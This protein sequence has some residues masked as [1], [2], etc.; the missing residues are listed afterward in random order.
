M[1]IVKKVLLVLGIELVI[2]F[3]LC[4]GI[5]FIVVKP[6]QLEVPSS[7]KYKFL[8][9]L[10][11]F[12]DFLPSIFATSIAM[13]YSWGF[14]RENIS[15]KTK[16]SSEIGK[17]LTAII[18]ISFISAA[19]CFVSQE[20]LIRFTENSKTKMVINTK[21]IL[22]YLDMA[23]K[24]YEKEEYNDASFYIKSVLDLNKNHAEGNA[25]KVQI[26]NKIAESKNIISSNSL[27]ENSEKTQK[28]LAPNEDSSKIINN[29]SDKNSM[30]ATQL[31]KLAQECFQTEDFINAHY[32]ASQVVDLCSPNETNYSVAKRLATESWANLSKTKSFDDELSSEVFAKKKESYVA[33]ISGNYSKAYYNFSDLIEKYPR[34]IDIKKYFEQAK[35]KL[36]SQCFFIDETENLQN[37]EQY[38]NVYFTIPNTYG[39]K[40]IVSIAGVTSIKSR[41]SMIMYLRD[42]SIFSYDKNDGLLSKMTVPYAKL[43]PFPI[44]DIDAATR[45]IVE[46][47][48]KTEFVPYIFL[49]S[50]DRKD[51]NVFIEPKYEYFTSNRKEFSTISILPISLDQFTMLCDVSNG[52]NR[53]NIISLFAFSKDAETYGYSREILSHSLLSRILFPLI[54]FVC[55]LFCG[56]IAWDTKLTTQDSFHFSWIILFPFLTVLAYSLIKIIVYFCDLTFY[57]LFGIAGSYAILIA[58]AIFV[59]IA[60]GL[61]IKI[62][63]VK[64]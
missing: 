60:I 12:F 21:N 63:S 44:E 47:K 46:Q 17:H 20:V 1:K 45:T 4:L 13:G 37:F 28:K 14:G 56:I 22:G 2:T 29:Y 11:V 3:V 42:F 49:K 25:L 5:S 16:F 6:P 55:F 51:K 53:M 30:S 61:S 8:S 35:E 48:F 19:F 33:L 64:D 36:S 18:I 15:I 31:L 54:L 41:N 57:A 58:F 9:G 50:V 43:I 27:Y 59:I 38:R 10:L 52:E 7:S 40:D 23:K 39:G 26:E 32:Y 34:D 24:S 62:S